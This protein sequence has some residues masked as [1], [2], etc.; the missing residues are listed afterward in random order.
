MHG[1]MTMAGANNVPGRSVDGGMTMA[2]DNNVSYQ[3]A[4][5]QLHK[6]Y[7]TCEESVAYST[8]EQ[9]IIKM[10]SI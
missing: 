7:S 9:G 3:I 1:G 5:Y 10:Y 6:A 8:C 4:A 2:G